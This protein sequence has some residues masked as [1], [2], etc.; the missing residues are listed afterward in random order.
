MPPNPPTGFRAL[1]IAKAWLQLEY[2]LCLFSSSVSLTLSTSVGYSVSLLSLA[3]YPYHWCDISMYDTFYLFRSANEISG[4]WNISKQ[5]YCWRRGLYSKFTHERFNIRTANR[6]VKIYRRV[7]Y[8][9]HFL[10]KIKPY[11]YDSS[12]TQSRTWVDFFVK[13]LIYTNLTDSECAKDR[14]QAT[15]Q[16]SRP[17]RWR[18]F[19]TRA[20]DR[21]LWPGEIRI[22]SS[23]F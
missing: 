8:F 18:S 6:L 20:R 15:Q 10:A 7:R 14:W 2:A 13:C 11:G 16:W 17:Q 4:Q 12:I 21:D 3:G 23:K 22:L 19:L 5:N 9:K 1:S